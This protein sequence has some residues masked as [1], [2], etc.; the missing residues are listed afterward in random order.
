MKYL[1]KIA[2]GIL[3]LA[4]S[5]DQVAAGDIDVGGFCTDDTACVTFC[6]TND[7]KFDT[8]GKCIE[9]EEDTRCKKRKLEYRLILSFIIIMM[10]V[11]SLV[12][13]WMK[14]KELKA[15]EDRLLKLKITAANE[16]RKRVERGGDKDEFADL[17][18]N[19]TAP[20]LGTAQVADESGF[21]GTSNDNK[22]VLIK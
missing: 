15:K 1:D 7:Q 21:F 10:V 18:A 6:C 9:I 20:K 2:G 13:G 11:I 8:E 16:E 3:S 4:L 12:F 22:E 17:L 14:K 19:K 5:A